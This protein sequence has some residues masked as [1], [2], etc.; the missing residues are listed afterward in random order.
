MAKKRIQRTYCFL[1]LF[2]IHLSVCGQSNN[3]R[4]FER[5]KEAK[6]WEEQSVKLS[7]PFTTDSQKVLAVY[8]WITE[9]I[10]YDYSSYMSGQPIRYQS[11]DRVYYRK[12][13]TCTGYSNLLV[14]MLKHVGIA[15]TDIEGFTHDFTLGLDSTK[16]SSDHAWVAFKADGKWF[17][18]DPTW[19]AGQIGIYAQISST[20]V[21]KSFWKRLKSFRLKNLFRKKKK[22]ATKTE[23]RVKVTYRYG[24]TRN[25]SRAYIFI[26]AEDFL[27]SHLPNVSHFQLMGSPIS[28]QQYCDSLHS[29]GNKVYPNKGSFNFSSL[30]NQ[31]EELERPEKLLWL[32]DSSLL[33]HHLNHGDK[34]INAH[35]YLASYYGERT[36]SIPMLDRFIS[37]SDTV[38][39]H[40]SI[41]I[42]L[43]KGLLNKKRKEFTVAFSEEKTSRNEQLKYMNFMR[44]HLGRSLE[45]YRKGKDR[46]L[47]KEKPAL[48][49]VEDRIYQFTT[50]ANKTDSLNSSNPIIEK[51]L[52]GIKELSDSLE[53][54]QLKRI[55]I[56]EELHQTFRILAD[57]TDVLFNKQIALLYEGQFLN[58][59]AIRHNDKLY[60][61]QLSVL[62]AF[63]KDSF[64]TVLGPR[65]SWSYLLRL[66]QEIKKQQLLWI[67][68]AKKDS[69]ID[70]NM[71]MNFAYSQLMKGVDRER[72]IQDELLKKAEILQLYLK[73]SINPT[74]KNSY[75]D[76]QDVTKLRTMRQAYLHKMLDNKYRRSIRVHQVL[77]T[78]AKTWKKSYLERKK[79]IT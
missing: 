71:A 64:N 4:F 7:A 44:G 5:K 73:S 16:L 23:T 17:L 34:A 74:I 54:L 24:F 55:T 3:I 13:T 78:N 63:V 10:S 25:P 20:V 56:A 68:A 19:D 15:A 26:P 46:I 27:K 70:L 58:E 2:F 37:Y 47:L 59:W 61:H 67:A 53:T 79:K 51:G 43:N 12:R 38:L 75:L 49:K 18:A 77:I 14:A 9:N 65:K 30:D 57:S 21:K 35:N 48:L 41:A 36:N 6:T 50:K 66:D 33:Y 62:N 32:S 29:L 11:H 45:I 28:M 72:L 42:K 31:F 22:K 60:T 39:L 69:T 52:Q 40:S 1:G 8:T 76:L